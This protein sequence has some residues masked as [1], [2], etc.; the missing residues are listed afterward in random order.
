[1]SGVMEP[2]LTSSRSSPAALQASHQFDRLI[3]GHAAL[4]PVRHRETDGQRQTLRP[5]LADGG[6]RL[7]QEPNA[8][9]EAAA[10]IVGAVVGE[11][12]VELVGEVAVGDSAVPAT[13]SPPP[14][15]ASPQR[16]TL[17][18]FV[19]CPR[20]SSLVEPSGDCRRREL[21]MGRWCPSRLGPSRCACC[22]PTACWH[23]PC[24]R[25]G[26]VGCQGRPRAAL[27]NRLMRGERLDMVIE[28]DAAV[29]RADPAF[30]RNGRGLDHDQP[31][32][33]HGTGAKM[34]EMPIVR[35]AVV[36]RILAHRRDGDAVPQHDILQPKLVEQARHD[37]TPFDTFPSC[38]AP[39]FRFRNDRN[40]LRVF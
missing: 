29:G 1:M 20:R 38:L 24:D 4:D 37:A 18:E 25:R 32:T 13:R 11:R 35:E 2:W 3:D 22:L 15:P 12:R 34:D 17:L 36:R 9:L 23:W 21:P 19:R 16:R 6:E 7:Q 14:A 10:V 33:A 40:G 26:R 5:D 8:V 27:R 30:R 28:I 39:V 31:S